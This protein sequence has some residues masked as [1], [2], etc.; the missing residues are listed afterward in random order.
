MSVERS[1][2]LAF[3]AVKGFCRHRR[4]AFNRKAR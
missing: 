3:F 4:R 1:L 2:A